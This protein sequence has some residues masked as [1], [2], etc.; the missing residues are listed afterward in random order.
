MQYIN[1][2]YQHIVH[3]KLIQLYVSYIFKKLGVVLKQVVSIIILLTN[4]QNV[5][6]FFSSIPASVWSR[7]FW[8]L[9]VHLDGGS[10]ELRVLTS[11]PWLQGVGRQLWQQQWLLPDPWIAAWWSVFTSKVPMPQQT[12]TGPH[13]HKLCFPPYCLWQRWRQVHSGLL[14]W[15]SSLEVPPI[16]HFSIPFNN[17]VIS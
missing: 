3:L 12:A 2:L 15:K 17:F 13:L 5:W 1:V 16:V 9:R 14:F 7:S 10:T 4:S 8:V 11:S 6:F